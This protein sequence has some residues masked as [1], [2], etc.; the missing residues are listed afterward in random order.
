MANETTS[1]SATRNII[2]TMITKDLVVLS[3]MEFSEISNKLKRGE[4]R[5]PA[6]SSDDTKCA[7]NP[8][9]PAGLNNNNWVHLF[10]LSEYN[11]EE[12]GGVFKAR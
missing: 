6:H 3:V 7:K 2:R 8:F 1:T 5:Y 10:P 12:S 4:K 11:T 9:A